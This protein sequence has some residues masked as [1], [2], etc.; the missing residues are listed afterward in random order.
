MQPTPSASAALPLPASFLSPSPIISSR[1]RLWYRSL[2]PLSSVC[3]LVRCVEGSVVR[4][5][6]P[7][8][9]LP[10][11]C[12]SF[13]PTSAS[14]WY[15]SPSPSPSLCPLP[16]SGVPSDTACDR[17]R[18]SLL[19]NNPHIDCSRTAMVVRGVT[20]ALRLFGPCT[21]HICVCCRVCFQCVFSACAVCVSR[22]F[23]VCSVSV[24][25]HRTPKQ[26][27]ANQS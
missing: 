3:R 1:Q 25:V 8:G 22:V 26:T 5:I 7:L 9:H 23:S 11:R 13:S 24:F 20:C 18:W 21:A 12:E 19:L 14:Q 6:C 15:M 16:V 10:F 4:F 27:K 17:R 2:P